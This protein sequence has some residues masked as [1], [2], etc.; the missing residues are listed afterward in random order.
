MS[1]DMQDFRPFGDG[2]RAR[3]TASDFARSA[4][5]Q[6]IPGHQP[7]PSDPLA[8]SYDFIVCGSVSSG[9]VIARRLAENLDVSVLLLEAGGSDDH[10]EVRVPSRWMQNF[11][12]DRL[13]PYSSTPNEH[14]HDRSVDMSMGKILGGGSSIN[15]TCWLRGHQ[16]D[17]NSFARKTADDEWGYD[18]ILEVY[19][20]IERWEGA[21]DNGR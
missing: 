18:S 20:G 3:G 7:M 21:T 14:L 5:I 9:S 12:I 13:W 8:R 6:F 4:S 2:A 17:W 19:R 10:P 11:G 1:T 16:A 15:A